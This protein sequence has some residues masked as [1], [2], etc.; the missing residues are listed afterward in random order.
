MKIA[1]VVQRCGRDVFGGAEALTFQ[2]GIYLSQ[3]FEIEILTTRAKDAITWKNYYPE[4]I[5]KIGNLIIRRF[6]V[7]KERDHNFVP[8]SQ[9]L[10]LNNNDLEKG[11]KFI[12]YSGPISNKL[13][14]FIENNKDQYDLFVFVG[15]LYWQTYNCLPLV[16][17]KSILLPTAHDESWIHFKIF[18]KVFEAPKGYLFLTN[19]EK[20]FV[21]NKFGHMEKPY[22]IIGHGM[23]LSLSL[24]NSKPPQIKLPDKYVLYIGRISAGKGCQLLS[25]YFN[26]YVNLQKTDLK[27]VMLGTREHKI[28]NNRAL[29]LENLSDEEKYFVL[30]NCK[31]FVMPSQF[32]SLNIACLEAWLFTKPVLVN[33][34]SDVLKDH[35]NNSNGGLYFCNYE[36]FSEYLDLI[37]H[38]ESFAKELSD[39]GEKYVKE[40]YNWDVTIQKY[41]KFFNEILA[42]MPH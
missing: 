25:D 13:C 39:N 31:L 2:I 4:G 41:K 28:E 6:D 12:E 33:G 40:N 11:E 27:L 37:L 21:H 17:E 10:E 32:E 19:A 38:D 23:D 7:D 22:Q 1:F 8:L 29:V 9:Y 18:E 14:N 30:K 16:S 5:E 20:E 3:F 24:K 35:C 15:Y 36:E 26:R 42:I 34:K